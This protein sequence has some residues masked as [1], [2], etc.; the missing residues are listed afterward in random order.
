M[1]ASS[2]YATVTSLFYIL[3]RLPLCWQII[4]ITHKCRVKS[5]AYKMLLKCTA[6]AIGYAFCVHVIPQMPSVFRC[7]TAIEYILVA[8][9]T[10][11]LVSKVW[12][13]EGPKNAIKYMEFW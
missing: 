12:G 7:E 10:I 13:H 8:N 4:Q 11:T 9:W 6:E 5:I 3:N 1:L 2:I